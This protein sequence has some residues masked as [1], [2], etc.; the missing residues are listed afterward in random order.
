MAR[1]NHLVKS[2]QLTLAGLV[3]AAAGGLS[4]QARASLPQQSPGGQGKADALVA[5]G[6]AALERND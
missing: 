2:L 1:S 4:L 6:V 3:L 5:E